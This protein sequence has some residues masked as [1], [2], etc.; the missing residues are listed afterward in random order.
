M[1]DLVIRPGA[2]DAEAFAP[3]GRFVTAPERPGDR[4]F[5]SDVLQEHGPQSTPVLHVNHVPETK[6]PAQFTQV[7]RHSHAAQCFFPLDVSRYVVVVIPSNQDGD[8]AID[9]SL[10]FLM[11]GTTGVIYHPNVWH[12]GATVL[13]RPGHFS[14]LMW[15][16]G[17]HSDDKFR[18][19]PPLTLPD[20]C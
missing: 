20:N 7:E 2:P 9:R 8:P 10:A 19:I 16:D 14:V 13:D 6:L 1:T 18:A 4:M 15:R 17:T 12:L 3:F 11:P 5:Y